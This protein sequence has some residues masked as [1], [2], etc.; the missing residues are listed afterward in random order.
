MRPQIAV[1]YNEPDPGRYGALGEEKAVRGVMDAVEAVYAALQELGYPATR[2]ALS[3]PLERA[4]ETL[5]KVK[6][7]LVFNLFEGFPESPK[8]EALIADTLE[9]RGLPFTGCSGQALALA[10]DKA[11]TKSLLTESGINTPAFQSLGPKTL[12][13]F[14]LSF[15]CIVKPVGEDASHGLTE[16]SVVHNR[17]ALTAQVTRVSQL[18]GGKAL[19]EEFI[20]GREFNITVLGGRKPIALPVS[21]IVFSLPPGLPSILTYA[22]K[23]EESSPY[24]EGTEAVCPADIDNGLREEIGDTALRVFRLLCGSGYARVD[25]RMDSKRKLYVLEVNPN[26]DISPGTGAARQAKAAGMTHAQFVEKLVELAQEGAR[27]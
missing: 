21:E 24:F 13:S 27:Q 14:R 26:P 3:P 15:P 6:A 5:R 4:Q 10:L 11:R 8:T 18:Y 9:S 19:V 17:A 22:A 16:D 23:W 1:I 20:D 2:V 25:F 12:P 7:D